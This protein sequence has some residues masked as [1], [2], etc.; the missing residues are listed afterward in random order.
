[1]PSRRELIAMTQ[2]EVRDY[3]RSQ[4]R[5]IVVSNG[6]GGFPHPV[7]MN[8][9]ID[10][11][12]R[13]VILTFRKSQKVLNLERDP[14]AALL[15]ESGS[16]YHELKSVMI[17]AV[18]EII[19]DAEGLEAARAA[20]ASKVHTEGLT[21]EAQGQSQASMV[22]RVAVRF[23]PQRTISWDHGKLGGRY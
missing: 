18:A 1:M 7:P 13:P 4:E 16:A 17:Y 9:A 11:Q 14:R 21:A 10:D 8:F 12:D 3:L 5:L 22:K 6:L 20:F 23:T 15:V 19:G 2:E